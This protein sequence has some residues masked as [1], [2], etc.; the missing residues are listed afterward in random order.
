MKQTIKTIALILAVI[1]I[2]TILI[3]YLKSPIGEQEPV[4]KG[5]IKVF[6]EGFMSTAYSVQQTSD[7]GYIV[8]GTR[9][10]GTRPPFNI[11]LFLLKTDA[12]GNEVWDRIFGGLSG[13]EGR[14]VQQTSDGEYVVAGVY[15]SYRLNGTIPNDTKIEKERLDRVLA[16]W[17]D[18]RYDEW[19]L[20]G[21][22]FYL[23]KTDVDGNMIWE[24][25]FGDYYNEVGHSLQ[26]TSDGGYIVVGGTNSFGVSPYTAKELGQEAPEDVYLVKTDAD[27]NEQW[28][29][30]FGWRFLDIGYSVQQTNDGG[31]IIAGETAGLQGNRTEDI[32]MGDDGG[33]GKLG[34]TDVYLIKTDS[35]GN[36]VWEKTFGGN[37]TNEVAYSVQ[38][39][40]DKGYIIAGLTRFTNVGHDNYTFFDS[41]VYLIKTD[42]NGNKVWER[43]FDSNQPQYYSK[44]DVAYS[45]QQTSDEGYI[46]AGTTKSYQDVYLIK[47]DENGNKVWEKTL[48]LTREFGALQGH[49]VQQ[50]S[51]GG[52]VITG[53]I[54]YENEVAKGGGGRYIFLI[55]TDENGN[56]AFCPAGVCHLNIE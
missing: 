26:Q 32:Y 9:Y 35:D 23:V 3:I 41:D 33:S 27:G 20:I 52:Y 51:D 42:E 21:D 43:K 1:A 14:S 40:S 18:S 28:T 53:Y 55:K 36:K 6:R 10:E 24:K 37:D 25:T 7:G 50:T 31:Y 15:H 46:I 29:K 11:S 56:N 16:K 22:E 19:Y 54:D 30:V 39:T 49:S 48:S 17:P 2:I 8:A 38:Q 47:T 44:F 4:V 13:D 12:Q 45:I 34:L 5:W